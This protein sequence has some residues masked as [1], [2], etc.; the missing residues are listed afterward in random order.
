MV[1]RVTNSI[2]RMP[3]MPPGNASLHLVWRNSGVV[4]DHRDHGNL[5]LGKDIHRHTGNRDDSQDGDQDGHH[6][7]RVWLFQSDTNDPHGVANFVKVS[8]RSSVVAASRRWLVE[9]CVVS[10]GQE[11]FLWRAL[12][13]TTRIHRLQLGRVRVCFNCR[14]GHSID[15]TLLAR[16]SMF[17]QQPARCCSVTHFQSIDGRVMFARPF[18]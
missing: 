15:P 9:C 13:Q 14:I 12:R 10:T 3:L 17:A 11:Q 6:D 2:H 18:N 8:P 5:N 16:F 1:V 4:P 7:E